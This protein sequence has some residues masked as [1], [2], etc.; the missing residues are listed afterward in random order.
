MN[1]YFLMFYSECIEYRGE[2]LFP[3]QIE[4]AFL[5]LEGASKYPQVDPADTRLL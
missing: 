2:S 1:S 4:V 3:L 5:K